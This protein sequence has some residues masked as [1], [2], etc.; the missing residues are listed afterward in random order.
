MWLIDFYFN[1][2]IVFCFFPFQID[3]HFHYLDIQT[4]ESKKPSHF[5]IITND[6]TYSFVTTGDAGNFSSVCV[7]R[8]FLS[9][10]IFF[11]G[12]EIFNDIN[13]C[14]QCLNWQ[15]KQKFSFFPN[16]TNNNNNN[17]RIFFFVFVSN[18]MPTLLWPIWHRQLNRYFQLYH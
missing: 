5:S 11:S 14:E 8:T 12:D 18:R 7:K 6:R 16:N 1:E 15:K 2:K 10:R 3:C 9:F 17:K 4:V 13:A